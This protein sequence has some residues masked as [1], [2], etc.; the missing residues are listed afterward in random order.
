MPHSQYIYIKGFKVCVISSNVT[1]W[2]ALHRAKDRIIFTVMQ[3]RSC[4]N[5]FGI[6][7]CT[8]DACSMRK[9]SRQSAVLHIC[10]TS[11]GSFL[12]SP[13]HQQVA[14]TLGEEGQDAQL[15]DRRERQECKQVVPPRLLE[16]KRSTG[17]NDLGVGFWS[18]LNW[19]GVFFVLFFKYQWD[20]SKTM[21]FFVVN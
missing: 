15:Q 8:F 10:C 16:S 1:P 3:E 2:E 14:R 5:V 18:L 6:D 17:I 11:F 19:W 20:W 9:E 21:P 7:A 13:L 12:I 4:P